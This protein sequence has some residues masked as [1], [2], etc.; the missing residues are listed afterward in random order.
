MDRDG[1]TE[2]SI[3]MITIQQMVESS[4]KKV[5]LVPYVV[6]ICT[7]SAILLVDSNGKRMVMGGSE[8][9]PR[10]SHM[11]SLQRVP[12]VILEKTNIFCSFTIVK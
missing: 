12:V 5:C 3:T 10:N 6:S 9:G 4:L 1:P 8:R 7:L 11:F 2:K